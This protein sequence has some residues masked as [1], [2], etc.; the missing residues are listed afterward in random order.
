M[1]EKRI[2]MIN[3]YGDI[4]YFNSGIFYDVNEETYCVLTCLSD[5]DDNIGRIDYLKPKDEGK[6]WSWDILSFFDYFVDMMTKEK[7]DPSNLKPKAMYYGVKGDKVW[8]KIRT[9]YNGEIVSGYTFGKSDYKAK[10]L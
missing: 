10:Q 1:N 9:D 5:A 8:W 6:T 7:V 3:E 4:A 2:V